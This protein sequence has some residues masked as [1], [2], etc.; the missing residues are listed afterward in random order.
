MRGAR[1]SSQMCRAL[2]RENRRWTGDR[3]L[4]F[5]AG[6][7]LFVVVVSSL[8]PVDTDIAMYWTAAHRVF[9]LGV[10][11][12]ILQSGDRLL[13]V[14]P[15]T[16]FF[17]LYPF[18]ELDIAQSSTLMLTVNSVL[19][20]MLMAMIVGDLARDDPSRRLVLWGPLYVA[21]FGGLYLNIIFCQ[22][23]LIVLL[24]LWLYWR[25]VR[26]S[27]RTWSSGGAL[28]LG[29]VAKPHY[30]LLALGAGPKPGYRIIVGALIA[31]T[32]LVGGS[33]A[34][35]PDGSW[36]TWVEGVLGEIG[37]TSLP[38]NLSSIAAPWNRSIPG[39]V[40]RFLIP[41]KYVDPLV[42]SPFAAKF[43]STTVI[44]VL[45]AVSAW[46]LFR[47]IR[48]ADREP[49]DRDLEL[50]L[51]SIFVFLAAP[52]SWTHHLVMLLPASLVMLR[53]CV[54]DRNEPVTSR[55]T[56]GLILVIIA[57]TFDDLIPREIRTSSLAIMSLMTV[58]V[59]ALWLLIVARLLRR[60][61]LCHDLS[62]SAPPSR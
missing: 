21:A 7:S 36:D 49:R 6:V 15:P 38:G 33:L 55:L 17:L 40:A 16:A 24:F 10:D 9:D 3:I 45:L 4:G 23:N 29:C 46:A 20:V 59:V 2:R 5:V 42:D 58:A 43:L 44:L 57:F 56:V 32:A 12:Y 37:Y 18:S 35:A 26:C 13:F 19:A 11:P 60:S 27:Q 61:A 39:F 28:V 1:F 51:I 54:L 50:S 34:L 48:R 30:F 62:D 52:A 14:Y 8:S 25:Q 47:S 31:G 41:N 22:I 53:D